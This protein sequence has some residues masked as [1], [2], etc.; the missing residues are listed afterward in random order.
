MPAPHKHRMTSNTVV[1]GSREDTRVSSGH[2]ALDDVRTDPGQIHQHDDHR[3]HGGSDSAKRLESRPEGSTHP[4]G[5]V[6]G[7]DDV[8]VDVDQGSDLV[9]RGADDDVHLA[10]PAG[11][12]TA[13]RALEPRDAVGIGDQPLRAAKAST[14]TR[15]QQKPYDF[16]AGLTHAA[17]LAVRP[18]AAESVMQVDHD[19]LRLVQDADS[20]VGPLP[21]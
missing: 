12:E 2:H 5:P 1:R 14:L 20:E 11:V 17:Y 16:I 8:V 10:A 18:A 3:R 9:S 7:H 21:Q 4:F 19:P 13:S 15:S 6:V